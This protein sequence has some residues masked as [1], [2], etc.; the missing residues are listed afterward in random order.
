VS[1]P[2]API[3]SWKHYGSRP[4]CLSLSTAKL[5][6]RLQLS[7]CRQDALDQVQMSPTPPPLT[8]LSPSHGTG[9]RARS[10]P[11]WCSTRRSRPM[12]VPT[13]A[14]RRPDELAQVQVLSS[15]TPS[16]PP[17][18]SRRGTVHNLRSAASSRQSPC[19]TTRPRRSLTRSRRSRT[20][21]AHHRSR[22]KTLPAR[23]AA[24]VTLRLQKLPALR[25]ASAPAHFA[26][27]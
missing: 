18:P 12:C 4:R 8:T 5:D 6:L 27:L 3:S 10:T 24:S 13:A 14:A 9:P 21:A 23:R 22:Q 1:E 26:L 7:G 16:P 25:A 15:T 19:R 2:S 20:R 11:L 17:Q